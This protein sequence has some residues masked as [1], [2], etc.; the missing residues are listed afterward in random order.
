MRSPFLCLAGNTSAA[1]DVSVYTPNIK[2]IIWLDQHKSEGTFSGDNVSW[3]LSSSA[4]VASAFNSY[5]VQSN[6]VKK[7]W[8]RSAE[9]S[10]ATNGIDLS[11]SGNVSDSPPSTL[12]FYQIPTGG[13]S[14]LRRG[15]WMVLASETLLFVVLGFMMV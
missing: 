3:S 2:M 6:S 5:I 15:D 1:V 10:A 9:F 12:P 7:Y 8:L 13:T 14:D 4:S 11:N